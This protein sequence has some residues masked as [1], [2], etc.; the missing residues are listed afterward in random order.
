MS[1]SCCTQSKT[2]PFTIIEDL[3]WSPPFHHPSDLIICKFPPTSHHFGY[4]GLFAALTVC[5]VLGTPSPES[6]GSLLPSFGS[7]SKCPLIREALC[8]TSLHQI[9][10]LTPLVLP[11]DYHLGESVCKKAGSQMWTQT[12]SISITWDHDGHTNFRALLQ[13]TKQIRIWSWV[14]QSVLTNPVTILLTL[15][16]TVMDFTNI[17]SFHPPNQPMR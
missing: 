13:M 11:D 6:Q 7:L 2:M 8:L 3:K 1:P 10:I 12:S 15:R 17:M 14:Q 9:A 4:T 5:P 16:T